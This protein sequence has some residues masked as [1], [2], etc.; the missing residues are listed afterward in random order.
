MKTK[1][2][3]LLALAVSAMFSLASCNNFADDDVLSFDNQT[4]IGQTIPTVSAEQRI[5]ADSAATTGTVAY[6]APVA[7]TVRCTAGNVE[8]A[9]NG[10]GFSYTL[11]ALSGNTRDI[12]FYLEP[13][14]RTKYA[15]YG[16]YAYPIRLRQYGS[17]TQ[18]K[19]ADE[20]VTYVD[21]V[22]INDQWYAKGTVVSVS[23]IETDSYPIGKYPVNP[24]LF[25]DRGAMP[26]LSEEQCPSNLDEKFMT[27]T[28][29][30]DGQNV[31][32]LVND[33][34]RDS[35]LDD[36]AGKLRTGA[37]VEISLYRASWNGAFGG[38]VNVNP[39]AVFIL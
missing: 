37:E 39:P 5:T 8:L 19:S 25:Y 38:I 34:A 23:A 29:A 13:A 35:F 7:M 2:F 22:D 6:T 21:K 15:G 33:L 11:P 1:H 20:L 18:Y 31:K 27:V 17:Q 32:F 24:Q 16:Y 10:N 3:T 9:E 14:V 26:G 30:I 4:L 36:L 12:E 28:V